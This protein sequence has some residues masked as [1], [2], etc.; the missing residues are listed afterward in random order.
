[1]VL[2]YRARHSYLMS[3]PLSVSHTRIGL[4][5]IA[6]TT[7]F[8]ILISLSGCHSL[9]SMPE[10]TSFAGPERQA[11]DVAFFADRTWVEESGE[12]FVEQQVFDELF[13]LID[14]ARQLIVLDMFLFN[15]WQGPIPE[16][17][18]ALSDELTSRLLKARV[19]HPDMPIVVITDPV[20]TLYNGL[21]SEK[22]ESLRNGNIKVVQTNLNRLRDSNTLYSPFWR[23]LFKPFGNSKGSLLPNPIGPGRVSVR[24]YL[25]LFNFK[26]NH[27]KTLVVDQGENLIGFVSSA[28]PHDGSSAHR[29]VAIRFSGP[30]VVD[31]LSTENAALEMSD[32]EPVVV[33]QNLLDN[34]PT[35]QSNHGAVTVQVVTETKIQDAILQALNS[36]TR[37]DRVDLMM[38]Y[39]SDR[40][41]KKALID[42]HTRGAE[43]RI[44][45]DPNKDAF[46]REKNGVPNRPNARK[47]HRTGLDV[48]WCNSQGEQCHTKMLLVTRANQSTTLISGSANFTRRNLDDYNLET[49]VVLRGRSDSAVIANAQTYF[50][51]MWNNH[52]D[53]LYSS[54]YSAYQ[55]DSLWHRFLAWFMESSGISSF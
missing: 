7:L 48:R 6:A 9:K 12:R 18:R 38:F 10:G 4:K 11:S 53:R 26:A 3:T 37:G 30:A 50:N 25:K 47:L 45:L 41:V 2:H 32:A 16:T 46:G 23:L 35:V 20:N 1:M 51:D 49:D 42:A 21:S 27:R 19:N 13:S 44:I 55:D 28:N 5:G 39:L 33:P 40:H 43:T 15:D 8:I 34:I 17:T 22:F 54:D 36:A 29:N 52:D 14:G 31:L 24:T